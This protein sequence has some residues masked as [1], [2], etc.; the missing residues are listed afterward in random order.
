L[1]LSCGDYI[2]LKHD[3]PE[4]L[5]DLRHEATSTVAPRRSYGR[6]NFR[7][8]EPDEGKTSTDGITYQ[9]Y[10]VTYGYEEQTKWTGGIHRGNI[11]IEFGGDTKEEA[12]E[13]FHSLLDIYLKDCIE[14]GGKQELTDEEACALLE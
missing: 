9:S 6:K 1:E 14:S 8:K 12:K 7:T 2:L 13:E 3:P 4:F 5:A 10:R 11:F